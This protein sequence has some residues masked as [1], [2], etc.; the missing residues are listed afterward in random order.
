ML[1]SLKNK[2]LKH[3]TVI[4]VGIYFETESTSYSV[5]KVSQKNNSLILSE[6][7]LYHSFDALEKAIEKKWPVILNFSGKGILNKKTDYTQTC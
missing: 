4:V 6:Q 7:S 3:T 2:L 1:N 5:I